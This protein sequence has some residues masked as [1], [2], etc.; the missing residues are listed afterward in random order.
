MS[1]FTPVGES[2]S[3]KILPLEYK[4]V[5]NHA[6]KLKLNKGYFQDFSSSTEEFVPDF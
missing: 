1:Q 3:R 6:E 2:K 5:L 4:L